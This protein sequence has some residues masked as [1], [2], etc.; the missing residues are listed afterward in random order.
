MCPD[1]KLYLT[2]PQGLR[3]ERFPCLIRRISRW[4]HTDGVWL[5]YGKSFRVII[6]VRNR[7]CKGSHHGK[8]RYSG[9]SN[10]STQPLERGVCL[11]LFLSSSLYS[12]PSPI[13][14]LDLEFCKVPPSRWKL[15]DTTHSVR[16]PVC[17]VFGSFVL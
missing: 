16:S 13:F 15:W 1:T 5:S 6:L 4:Y 3:P 12:V 17:S 8:I 7:P 10:Q 9:L 2:P 11:V 14:F